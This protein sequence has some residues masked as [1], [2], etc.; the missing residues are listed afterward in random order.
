MPDD[1]DVISTLKH[2]AVADARRG[3]GQVG[4]EGIASFLADGQRLVA[5]AIEARAEIE[6]VFFRHPVEGPT[7]A[8]LAK[9][10]NA[11]LAC[12][13]VTRGIFFRILGLGYETSVRVL[14]V[15]RRPRDDESPTL[16]IGHEDS[17]YL[18]GERIQD[19]R[20]VGVMVRTADAWGLPCVVF[21][22]RTADPYSRAAVRSSTGSIFRVPLLAAPDLPSCLRA[23]KG[24][25]V[26]I[27]GTS[28]HARRPCWEAD[29]RGPCAIVLGNESTGLT[30]PVSDT[31]DEQVTIPMSGGAS[32]FNVT[33]AAGILLYERVR[34]RMTGQ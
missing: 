22:A 20:N 6:A 17:C 4:S 7:Q 32:S 34:Q 26:R 8:V 28:S 27:I 9:A 23:L 11:G 31:C 3:L 5:H 14:T 15:V 16:V 1:E 25:G 24:R 12:H 19:P 10:L 30:G 29:L 13:I 21:G 33:V 2:P 18:V